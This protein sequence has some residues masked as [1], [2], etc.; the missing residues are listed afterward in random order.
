MKLPNRCLVILICLLACSSTYAQTPNTATVVVVVTDQSGAVV[1]EAHIN[2]ANT[3][4]GHQRERQSNGEG[5]ATF[6]ALPLTGAYTITVTRSGFTAD[7]IQNVTLRS[8]ETATIKV[9]LVAAGGST[10]GGISDPDDGPFQ[11][12]RDPEGNEFCLVT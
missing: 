9:R 5:S 1:P 8:A 11:I 3:Q 10:F 12:M 4:T 6:S 2:V 7:P